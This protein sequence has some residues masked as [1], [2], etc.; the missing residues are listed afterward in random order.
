MPTITEHS[1][2]EEVAA[3][4]SDAL[5]NAGITATLSG[6]SADT[7]YTDNKYLSRDLD[8]VTSAMVADL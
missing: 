6:G 8:F 7:I 3:I 4:V 1:T 2:L 5:E